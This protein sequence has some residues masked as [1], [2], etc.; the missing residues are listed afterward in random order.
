MQFATLLA[1]GIIAG[2]MKLGT[3]IIISLLAVIA[4]AAEFGLYMFFGFG[5]AITGGE[6]AVS[7]VAAFFVS[8][9]ILTAVMGVAAPISAVVQATTKKENAGTYT[10]L[11]L[12]GL[13]LIVLVGVNAFRPKDKQ[14]VVASATSNSVAVKTED[15]SNSSEVPTPGAPNETP[16]SDLEEDAYRANILVR[17]VKVSK[18]I[19]D[20]DGVFG[21]IK[22]DGNRV[23]KRVELTVYALGG[24]GKP[25]FDDKFYP[26]LDSQLAFGDS[27]EPLKANY[28]R[29]FGY[30]L[31]APSE[32]NK[33]VRVEVTKVE[34]ADQQSDSQESVSPTVNESRDS[35][36]GGEE[37]PTTGSSND[38]RTEILNR[39]AEW[40]QSWQDRD[41]N[42]FLSFYDRDVR[43]VDA[44]GAAYGYKTLS[45]RRSKRWKGE[46]NIQINDVEKPTLEIQGNEATMSA[47]KEY[48]SSLSHY[49]G[50]KTLTWT[51]VDGQ[52][53]ITN[54][55]FELQEGGR[56]E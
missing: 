55:Q 50:L 38:D 12:M 51:K 44:D 21:E 18:T 47:V 24:D 11:S 35:S 29:K 28:S 46:R 34:F 7:G 53:L 14:V 41:V 3:S 20:E 42:T 16:Q 31:D 19:L 54:E 49:T 52:W 2:N 43:V 39:Y 23:L 56:K 40:Q 37:R 25:V 5:A 13:T 4:L 22:N 1:S 8:L 48:E 9:M 26:V 30:K 15:S 27:G 17:N 33:K 10:F 45:A 36:S 32:W 6:S